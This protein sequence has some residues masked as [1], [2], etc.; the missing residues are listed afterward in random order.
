MNVKISSM[1][2][3]RALALALLATTASCGGEPE[4]SGERQEKAAAGEASPAGSGAGAE[5]VAL[6]AA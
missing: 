6:T 1:R 5:G 3:A 4:E 2:F